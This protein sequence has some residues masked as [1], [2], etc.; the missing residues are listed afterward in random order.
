MRS[1]RSV[2]SAALL[3]ILV[4]C[5][6]QTPNGVSFSPVS[7]SS[8]AGRSILES[9]TQ[10]KIQHVVIIVQENRTVDNLF[11]FLRGA[12][13][14]SYGFNSQ[15][16]QIALRPRQLTAPYNPGHVH[17]DFLAAYNNGAMNGFDLESC[18]GT[19]PADMA[20][21]YVPKN[22]VEPYYAMAEA[23]T[24]ADEMFQTNQGPSFPAH[25]YLVSGTSTLNNGSNDRAASNPLTSDG[26]LTGGCDAPRGSLVAVINPRGGEPD[27]LRSYPCFR[28]KALMNELDQA[29]ISWRYY[30]ATPGPG[31]WNAVDA[32]HSIWSNDREYN[33]NVV[34]PSARV[35]RDISRQRLASVV[36][37]TPTQA[38]SDH[39]KVN[40]GSGPSWVA[41]VVNAIGESSYWDNTA[42]FVVWDDWGGFYDHV[43]P[44]IVNAYELSFRVPMIVI[45]PYARVHYVSHTPYEFGSILKFTEKVFGLRSLR[46]TDARAHDLFDCFDFNRAP[47]KFQPIPTRY[48]PSYFFRQAAQ[49]P[50]D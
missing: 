42:I 18:R 8:Q 33:Q 28:R 39:P 16:Q 29:G 21:A 34:T 20:Y 9:V 10:S 46:T 50:E 45:S 24:F 2:G 15:G 47:T 43:A 25:Q 11:Q 27:E 30:Q 13:T 3:T 31:I 12:N 49:E 26:A 14:Q 4:A 35:L 1:V 17:L 5:G 38:A 36:W 48:P 19:C 6:Q 32:I 22:E 44:Q 37:V 23:Y 40:D 41:S 7:P